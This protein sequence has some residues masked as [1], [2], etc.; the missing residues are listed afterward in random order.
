[1]LQSLA[2]NPTS[3]ATLLPQPPPVGAHCHT[4]HDNKISCGSIIILLIYYY[5]IIN[6]NCLKCP[7]W[8][9]SQTCCSLEMCSFKSNSSIWVCFRQ[10]PPSFLQNEHFRAVL[11][12]GVPVSKIC[13]ML[14]V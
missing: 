9:L 4:K 12:D 7:S 3:L 2:C 1:M 6:S 8:R 11:A 14:M 5:Y 13:D 10:F